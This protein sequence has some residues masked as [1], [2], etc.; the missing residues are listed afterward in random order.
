MLKH[1]EENERR[2]SALHMD[3]CCHGFDNIQYVPATKDTA[4]SY[5]LVSVNGKHGLCRSVCLKRQD[6]E[7]NDDEKVQEEDVFDG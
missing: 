6:Q 5:V 4:R 2:R 3:D 7:D 1:V